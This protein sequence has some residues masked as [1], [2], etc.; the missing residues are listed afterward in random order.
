MKNI[1]LFSL[2]LT[3]AFCSSLDDDGHRV[4]NSS[5]VEMISAASYGSQASR[6]QFRRGGGRV[7][8]SQDVGSFDVVSGPTFEFEKQQGNELLYT[9]SS[10]V[11]KISA[12]SQNSVTVT[13]PRNGTETTVTFTP[14]GR[15]L[16]A[17]P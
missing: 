1:L 9:N 14:R 3:F 12:I 10:G 7:K 5:E 16:G 6:V 2:L 13:Y 4:P 17:R 8:V 15:D 11:A